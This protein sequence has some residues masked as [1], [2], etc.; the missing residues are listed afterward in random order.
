MF[1]KNSALLCLLCVFNF[2][3][4]SRATLSCLRDDGTPVDSWTGIK[5]NNDHHMYYYSAA[6]E[7]FIRSPYGVDQT[8]NGA[9]MLTVQPLYDASVNGSIAY[10]MYNDDPPNV[11]SASSTYAHAKGVLATDGT[12]GFWLSH[13]MPN[14]PNQPTGEYASGSAGIFPS[15]K[16]A[17]SM[18]C[19]TIS[20]STANEIADTLRVD[21]PAVYIGSI[22]PDIADQV[23]HMTELINKVKISSTNI[24]AANA[25]YT[26]DGQKYIQFAK[27]KKW[28]MDLW[29]DLIA[30]YYKTP[31]NVE[32]WISGSGGAMS[33]MCYNATNP[34]IEKIN[35]PYDIFQVAYIEMPDG[36]NWANTQDH[37]KWGVATNSE[38]DNN[39]K[40]NSLASCIGDINRM[41]SQENRGGGAMC[42][43][44]SGLKKA[45]TEIIAGTETCYLKDPCEDYDDDPSNPQCY[46]CPAQAA[47]LTYPPTYAPTQNDGGQDASSGASNNHST[48]GV[49]DPKMF[50]GL[51]IGA[52]AVLGLV[53]YI[54]KRYTKKPKVSMAQ[55]DFYITNDGNK[56]GSIDGIEK[57]RS[58]VFAS[59]NPIHINA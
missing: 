7:S 46:W 40:F 23:D 31:M 18:G 44:D 12:T 21:Y 49:E 32:T 24:T 6:N 15:D 9:L 41:C 29:D 3:N 17:Q 2:I 22:P 38:P 27:S 39:Q 48:F 28:A 50:F 52:A 56:T 51:V 54:V 55:Q 58:S 57:N 59:T 13:S 34:A 1:R 5:A 26:M 42:I 37:S 25:F 4:E 43:E 53:I 8:T 35:E 45:F 11:G 47:G 10:L 36:E 14:W 30:P 20:A 16:Y 33:S 19:V